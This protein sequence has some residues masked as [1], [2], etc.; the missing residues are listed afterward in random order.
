L[1]PIASVRSLIEAASYPFCQNTPMAASSAASR[2]KDRGRP[3]ALRGF[4]PAAGGAFFMAKPFFI[5]I[6]IDVAAAARNCCRP[7]GASSMPPRARFV[8]FP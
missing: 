8:A 1:T 4:A 7:A 2:S 6:N 5:V 3:R